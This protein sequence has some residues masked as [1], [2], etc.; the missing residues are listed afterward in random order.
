MQYR[1]IALDVDG[2]LLDSAHH[3]RPRVAAAVRAAQDAGATIALATGKL[4]G[5]VLPLLAEMG[6][7]GPQ[8]V[9]N[10]A[11]TR[12]SATG[13][14]LRFRPL[15]QAGH[16]L[17][18]RLVRQAD[19]S[20]LVS[21]FAL[22]M[23][24]MDTPHPDIGIFRE[25]GEGPP[26][27][28]PNLL[29]PE[30]PPA[31]KILLAGPPLRLAALRAALAP[32]LPPEIIMTTTTPDFLEFFDAEAGKGLALAALRESLSI[33]REAVL[34]IGD[35]ENDIPLLRAA[36]MAVAMANGAEATRAAADRI[37]PSNDED[38]VAV[39]LEELLA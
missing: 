6:V 24:Y 9:L 31:A 33:P 17:V 34:A 36:G 37:A 3:L 38:G 8:I 18:L 14:T 20:L 25:Y 22:D 10:G 1:L 23:I 11:A 21:H 19:P 32:L 7:S 39:V 5:S 30:L 4:M 16:Y 12:E 28:V 15:S 26:E 29:A 27:I 13:A 35:G 2:T